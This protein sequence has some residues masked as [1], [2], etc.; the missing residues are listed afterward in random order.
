MKFG[1]IL[2][3]EESHNQP[4]KMA[5]ECNPGRKPGDPWS[6]WISWARGWLSLRRCWVI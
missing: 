4:S 6:Q 3:E 2:R 5:A 1:F